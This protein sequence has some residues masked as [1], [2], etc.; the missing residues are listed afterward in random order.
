MDHYSFAT[1]ADMKYVYEALAL[2][3]EYNHGNKPTMVGASGE[4]PAAEVEST[5][6]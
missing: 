3:S 6:A 2:V 1:G 5:L 4:A